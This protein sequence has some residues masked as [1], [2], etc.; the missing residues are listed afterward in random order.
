M[1][2][3]GVIDAAA[4][5]GSFTINGGVE[6]TGTIIAENGDTVTF[7]QNQTAAGGTFRLA[8]DGTLAFDGSVP[9]GGTIDFVD[10]STT[11]L[12]FSA[13][14]ESGQTGFPETIPTVSG[15]Q[16]GNEIDLVPWGNTIPLPLGDYA[17]SFV[18]GS[19]DLTIN[20]TAY[21]DIPVAPGEDY[22]GDQFAFQ[23]DGGTGVILDIACFLPGTLIRTDQGEIAVENLKTGDT[24]VTLSSRTR[25]LCWIGQ[26]RALATRGQRGAATPVIVRKGAL[27]DNV[28]YQDLRITKGHSLYIDGVLIPVE[29]L[30]NH[31]SI[32]WD[33]RAQEV[34][35]FHLELDAHDVLIANGAAAE[36]YRDDG[37]RWLFSNANA[38]WDGPPQPPCAPVLTGG[39]MVDAIWR[40]LLDRSGP[41][42]GVPL[43]DDPDLHLV[44]DGQRLDAARHAGGGYVFSLPYRAATV[45][46]V[47]RAAVPQE[48][49]TGRDPRCLGVALGRL[50][51]RQGTRFRAIKAADPW[52][53]D[54]FHDFEA[55]SFGRWTNGDAAL[56]IDAAR[57]MVRAGG[58]RADGWRGHALH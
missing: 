33:D 22:T 44:M 42:A 32:L 24:I 12:R 56:P 37:N 15:F 28:P 4:A 25:R 20:G 36:S 19:I 41:R 29:F 8:T 1:V 35:V 52:L 7:T 14:P 2:N 13:I 46:I 58:D 31:R 49:G 50:V 34:S 18:S 40:R 39:A 26:G 27:A 30:V 5:G 9:S 6:N 16:A 21:V 10:S 53:V 47:S 45:R 23:S 38:G 43:T 48:L 11:M 3:Q 17:A 51:A 55:D 54:G 57:W